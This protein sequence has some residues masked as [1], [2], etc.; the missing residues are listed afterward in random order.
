ML[1]LSALLVGTIVGLLPGIGLFSAMVLLYPFLLP[2]PPIDILIFYAVMAGTSQFTGS[3][4]A[5]VVGAAGEPSSI[6][7]T[8]EGPL[9][10]ARGL[11]P[12]AISTTA[13]G[14]FIG[15]IIVAGILLLTID[16]I[17][18]FVGNFY[19][20]NIQTAL[21]VT[22]MT[23]IVM[24]GSNKFIVNLLYAIIGASL[25]NIGLQRYTSEPITFGIS[26]FS[27]GIPFVA[28][29]IGLY[30]LP[31]V[32]R[33]FSLVDFKLLQS[34]SNT[35]VSS[36]KESLIAVKENIAAALRGSAIGMFAGLVPGLTTILAS[37]FSYIVERFIRK[38]KQVYNE[39][40][41]MACLISAET[42]NNSGQLTSMLPL[43]IFGIPIVGSE[44][45]VL[46]L[47]ER[48][49]TQ[50]SLNTLLAGGMFQ[51]VAMYF[52]LGGF[53]SMFIAWQGAKLLTQIYKIPKNFLVTFL[54]I[55]SSVSVYL[56]EADSNNQLFNCLC[57]ATCLGFGYLLR[58]TDT[59]VILFSFLIYPFMEFSLVRFYAIHFS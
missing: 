43:M 35:T 18:A 42:A 4:T 19:N 22:V 5:C 59:S 38:R 27:N 37:N 49:G 21:F 40:G 55:I 50:V 6:P 12:L 24:A 3:I 58:K 13:I 41:D 15:T 28:L 32:L 8:K 17:S 48:G 23:I 20:N 56:F 29:A 53:V 2:L 11:G 52:I 39:N 25:A 30:S 46:D 44:V 9:L 26:A 1:F 57:F 54:V 45:I 33:A 10:F 34:A 16:H 51:T 14:S 31:Q 36:I 7:A 47:I